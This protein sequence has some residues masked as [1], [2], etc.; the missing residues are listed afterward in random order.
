MSDQALPIPNEALWPR[1]TL[2]DVCELIRRGTAPSYVEESNVFAIGQR[3]VTPSGFAP[4]FTR[5]HEARRMRGTL[6]PR[7]GD[8]LLNSTGT[9]TI[10]R[11]CVFDGNGRFIVDGHVTVIRPKASFADGR[12]I[13]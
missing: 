7:H 13:E 6:E 11:S 12:W 2:A 3:C 5:P 9:G 4:S 1:S 10:G 8:V